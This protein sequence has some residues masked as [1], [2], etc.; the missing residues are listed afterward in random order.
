MANDGKDFERMHKEHERREE[1]YKKLRSYMVSF[2]ISWSELEMA[3]GNLLSEILNIPHSRIA[4]AVYYTPPAFDTRV[5]IIDST[6]YQIIKENNDLSELT[7]L[8]EKLF[9]KIN[10]IREKRN[11]IA[12]GSPCTFLIN[13]KQHLRFAPP[14]FDIVR[15]HPKKDKRQLPGLSVDDM[16]RAVIKL[17]WV[18]DRVDDVNRML[19]S[20]HKKDGTL[21]D[22]IRILEE[23][24]QN[25][26]QSK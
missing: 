20:Y 25:M 14:A 10:E 21:S 11:L 2:S 19:V 16:K 22:K 6:I 8:W 15:I 13:G 1:E 5:K 23:N 9:K 7:K 18:I 17:Q 26:N 4:H 24:L 3:L 12:H